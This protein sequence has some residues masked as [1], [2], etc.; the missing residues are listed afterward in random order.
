[1]NNYLSNKI[2]IT[3]FISIILVLYI[4][5]IFN[6]P[7]DYESMI[8]LKFIQY[9]LGTVLGYLAVPFFF[10]L[11][12]YLF[13]LGNNTASFEM[14]YKLK[15]RFTTLFIPYLIACLLISVFY[16]LISISPFLEN[17]NLGYNS[18]FKEP[19]FILLKKCFLY[20]DNGLPIAY[21]LWFIRDLILIVAS[22]PLLF[23]FL[24]YLKWFG[25]FILFCL[26]FFELKFPFVIDSFLY[27]SIGSMFNFS[28]LKWEIKKIGI[29]IL[30]LYLCFNFF[31][32]IHSFILRNNLSKPFILM[33][34]SGL[35]LSY[36]QFISEKFNLEKFRWLNMA[37]GFTF[38]IYVY[39]SPTINIFRK[40][41]LLLIGV[42]EI[43]YIMSFILSP[44]LMT[45]TIVCLGF[46]FKKYAFKV[47]TVLSGGR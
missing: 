9:F 16:Y 24:K 3:S 4:H 33:G 43:G 38:F 39:H 25:I 13:F 22:T 28:P 7:N 41:I 36:D 31:E 35:W 26:S 46:F 6:N 12:G 1:M 18:L 30:V 20:T 23:Y 42:N 8:Y 21:H 2:K 29:V 44:I 14:K 17:K 45:M 10:I 37:C 47:Y 27:F 19:F 5:S 34:I 11:S 32:P 40:S 15:S